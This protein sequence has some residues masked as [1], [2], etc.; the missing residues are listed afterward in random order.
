MVNFSERIH[1]E[2]AVYVDEL[3]Q[4]GAIGD[5]VH[6]AIFGPHRLSKASR[7]DWF[8]QKKRFGGI[9][10]DIA[11]HQVDQFLYL[12]GST[13]AEVTGTTVSTLNVL[14]CTSSTFPTPSIQATRANIP[15]RMVMQL[16]TAPRI[17]TSRRTT[18]SSPRSGSGS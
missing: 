7:P 1:V 17:R 10:T 5:I 11:S 2:S 14:A 12:T 15:R 6:M 8:F 13:T 9:L 3:I 18:T 4:G 16:A